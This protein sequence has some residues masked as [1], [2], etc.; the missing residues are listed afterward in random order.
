MRRQALA[1]W[2]SLRRASGP[3]VDE[4]AKAFEAVL[5]DLRLMCSRVGLVCRVAVFE[6]GRLRISW[7]KPRGAQRRT[8]TCGRGLPT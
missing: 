1:V 6:D 4:W 5:R 2:A 7:W 8:P 3:E